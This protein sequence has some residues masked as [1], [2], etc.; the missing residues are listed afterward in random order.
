MRWVIGVAVFAIA[1]VTA[2]APADAQFR[3]CNKSGENVDVAIAYDGGAKAGFIAEGWFTIRNGRCE[4]VYGRS[5]NNAFF[6]LYA[7]G[8]NGSV[9][10]G[11]DDDAQGYSFC[12]SRKVFRHFQNRFGDN[13]EE[14][15]QR[16]NMESKIFFEVEVGDSR[17]WTQTLDPGSD[18]STPSPPEAG[19]PAPPPSA[20][21][22]RGSA[23]ERFPNLC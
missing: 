23:C 21:P 10:D 20:P 17:R 6:Y 12:I 1:W 18:H 19:A 13:S 15:C 7:E 22:P 8:A 11:E 9:W 4:T 5:L 2:V 14:T 3:V 16:H